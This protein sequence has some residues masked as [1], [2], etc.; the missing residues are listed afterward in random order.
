MQKARSILVFFLI[1][2][3]VVIAI[4]AISL[5]MGLIDSATFNSTFVKVVGTLA[6]LAVAGLLVAV[7]S[8]SGQKPKGK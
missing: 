4:L 6:V 1:I 8:D 3:V 2:I 5:L 7:L